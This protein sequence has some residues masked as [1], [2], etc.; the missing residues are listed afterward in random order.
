MEVSFPKVVFDKRIRVFDTSA[1]WEV[2]GNWKNYHIIRG[3]KKEVTPQAL[4]SDNKGDELIFNF[5]G[6]GVP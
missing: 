4:F 3:S 2:K 6:T 5:E 1:V